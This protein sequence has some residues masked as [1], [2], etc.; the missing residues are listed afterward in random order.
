LV[1]IAGDYLPT[2]VIRVNNFAGWADV[3]AVAAVLR[4]DLDV[5]ARAIA[6]FRT[7]RTA[8]TIAA[9]PRVRTARLSGSAFTRPG[10]TLTA[11]VYAGGPLR[12]RLIAVATVAGIGLY[13]DA[14]A[15]AAFR[16]SRTA[17][18]IAAVPRVR[19]A[20]L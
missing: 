19:T 16:T 9:V 12:T 1:S 7:G 11:T 2:I 5:D 4:V 10:G 18:T 15:I 17:G 8:D 6:A 14:R 13:V 3:A 20:R